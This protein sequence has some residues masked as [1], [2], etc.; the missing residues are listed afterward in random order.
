MRAVVGVGGLQQGHP[1]GP[2]GGGEVPVE[3]PKRG[4][5]LGEQLCVCVRDR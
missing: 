4:V 2:E 3:A 5:Q 1:G